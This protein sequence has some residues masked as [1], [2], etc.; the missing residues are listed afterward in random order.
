MPSRVLIV[1]ICSNTKIE[2]GQSKEYQS[3]DAIGSLLPSESAQI[4]FEGRRRIRALIT[5]GQISRDGKPLRNLPYNESLVHGPDFQ[6]AGITGG[7]L[8][9]PAMLRYEGRFYTELGSDRLS[10]LQHTQHHFLIISGLYGL[11]TPAEPIQCYSCH[12]PDHDDITKTWVEDSRLTEVLVAYIRKFSITKV[13][14]FTAVDVYRNLV[15]WE[16]VRNAAN[17]NV[18]HCFSKQFAGPPLLRPLGVVAKRF[19]SLPENDLLN[20][21]V[22]HSEDTPYKEVLFEAVPV[23]ES[24]TDIAREIQKQTIRFTYA[25]RIGRVRRNIVRILN[26]IPGA[27]SESDGFC[28]RANSLRGSGLTHRIADLIIEFANVRNSVEHELYQLSDKEWLEVKRKYLEI[29][30]WARENGYLKGKGWEKIEP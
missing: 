5:S 11:L 18:L 25:D 12:V 15:A 13:F 26:H 8:Y 7:G 16:M 17:G 14:D 19:L 27:H 1:T 2:E 10:V 3:S 20:I 29:E 22:G 24:R 4:L 30:S 28:N 21:E 9:L 23:P 6:L